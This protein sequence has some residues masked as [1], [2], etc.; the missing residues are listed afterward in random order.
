MVDLLIKRNA[1]VNAI[2][3]S[4]RTPLMLAAIGGHIKVVEKLLA[5]KAV[6]WLLDGYDKTALNHAEECL[7][8][9]DK[10]KYRAVTWLLD[11]TALN[12]VEERLLSEDKEKYQTIVQLLKDAGAQ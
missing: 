7:L 11:K 4:G 1:N 5:A 2:D 12:H 9:K 8:S 3:G 10:E 6:T